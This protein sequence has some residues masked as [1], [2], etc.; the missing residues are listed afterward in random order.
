MNEPKRTI[1]QRMLGDFA[2]WMLV[3]MVD[4]KGL[5]VWSDRVNHPPRWVR[6]TFGSHRQGLESVVTLLISQGWLDDE[7]LQVTENAR[8]L[9]AVDRPAKEG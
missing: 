4:D 1:L 7:T 5:I 2:Y 9:L 3:D 6:T 8:A